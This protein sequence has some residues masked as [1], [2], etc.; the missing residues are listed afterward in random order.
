LFPGGAV[1]AFDLI[2]ADPG[3]QFTGCHAHKGCSRAAG[4]NLDV[5]GV[6]DRLQNGSLGPR[7]TRPACRRRPSIH[8]EEKSPDKIQARRGGRSAWQMLG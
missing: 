1:S 6:V 4:V 5:A 3:F 2:A 7:K 8:E